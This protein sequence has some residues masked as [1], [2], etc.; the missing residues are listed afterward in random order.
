MEETNF[1]MPEPDIRVDYFSNHKLVRSATVFYDV[2]K[3]TYGVVED[4]SAEY[5]KESK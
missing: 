4:I 1:R 5:A 3:V 2:G